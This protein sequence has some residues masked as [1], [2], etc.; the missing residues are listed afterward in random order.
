MRAMEK[1]YRVGV[2][3]QEKRWSAEDRKPVAPGGASAAFRI[4]ARKKEVIR[5]NPY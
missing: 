1:G 2:M 4:D 3:G 5:L